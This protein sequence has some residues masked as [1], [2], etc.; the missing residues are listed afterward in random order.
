MSN[1][2]NIPSENSAGSVS[3]PPP[4]LGADVQPLILP[5]DPVVAELLALV[6]RMNP[7]GLLRLVERAAYLVEQFP[8]KPCPVISLAAWRKEASHD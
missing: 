4:P 3:L 8:C 5:A 6:Q 7:N 2:V 1:S